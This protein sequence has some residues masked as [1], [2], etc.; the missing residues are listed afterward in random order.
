MGVD[1]IFPGR[2]PGSS[3][4]AEDGLGYRR[5]GLAVGRNPSHDQTGTTASTRR[6]SAGVRP[7]TRPLIHAGQTTIKITRVAKATNTNKQQVVSRA[8][9]G[10]LFGMA[11][12]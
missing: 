7:R 12:R 4:I 9:W 11:I 8:V 1:T 3:Q 6:P 5:I 10:S 2:T